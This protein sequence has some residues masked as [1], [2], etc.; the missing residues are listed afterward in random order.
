MQ[1]KTI[2]MIKEK[3]LY[4][5]IVQVKQILQQIDSELKVIYTIEKKIE[6]LIVTSPLGVGRTLSFYTKTECPGIFY[7]A[8]WK[9]RNGLIFSV[10][11]TPIEVQKWLGKYISL[12]N[13]LKT[14][15]KCLKGEMKF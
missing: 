4:A 11:G 15:V 5:T 8:S 12:E 9:G 14:L 3:P 13:S 6:K 1:L 2:E 7:S 10:S